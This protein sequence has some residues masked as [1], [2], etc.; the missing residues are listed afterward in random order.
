MY[1]CMRECACM[2]IG[3]IRVNTD[4]IYTLTF[5]KLLSLYIQI[6]GFILA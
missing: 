6:P 5:H 2:H 3:S 1:K 4:D